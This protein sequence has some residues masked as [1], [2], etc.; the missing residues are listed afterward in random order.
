MKFE[1]KEYFCI[2]LDLLGTGEQ[3]KEAQKRNELDD[4]LVRFLNVVGAENH[5]LKELKKIFRFHFKLFSDNVF[6]A[7]LSKR[8]LINDFH[9]VLEHIIDYQ[10]SLISSNYFIRGGI[11]LGKLFIDKNNIWG[12]ALIESVEMEKKAIF[13]V[14]ILSNDIVKIFVENNSLSNEDNGFSISIIE[15]QGKYFLDYL[16]SVILK[17]NKTP[18]I[19]SFLSVHKR[20]VENNLKKYNEEKISNKY[21]MLA[22]YHN[23]FCESIKDKFSINNH[24]IKSYLNSKQYFTFKRK[25][26][27]YSL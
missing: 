1:L 17:G 13:P 7:L 20:F 21:K 15:F 12:P 23:Q 19:S 14:I 3:V 16:Y 26:I 11:A 6:I 8:E 24:F 18:I 5:Y 25:F 22:E 2:Y 9:L 27:N 4:S 10:K